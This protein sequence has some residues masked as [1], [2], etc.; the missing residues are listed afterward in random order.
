MIGSNEHEFRANYSEAKVTS[1][2]PENKIT[3]FF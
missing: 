1:I 3:V 2:I